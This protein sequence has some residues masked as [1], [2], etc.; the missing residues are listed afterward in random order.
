MQDFDARVPVPF[1]VFPSSYRNQKTSET[2]V[3][4]DE[5]LTVEGAGREDRHDRYS[6]QQPTSRRDDRYREDIRIT[7]EDRYRKGVRSDRNEEG[8]Y[9]G[10]GRNHANVDTRVEIDIDRQR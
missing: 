3:T 10:V 4:T 2:E 5:R 7:E 1:S 8:Q 9:T 6:Q